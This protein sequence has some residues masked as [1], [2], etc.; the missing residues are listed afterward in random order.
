MNA[1]YCDK[2]LKEQKV[3]GA[4]LKEA[5]AIFEVTDNLINL[6]NNKDI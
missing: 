2:D 4:V 5:F 1:Q 6:K 3:R